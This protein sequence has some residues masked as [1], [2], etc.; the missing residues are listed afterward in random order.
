MCLHLFFILT[1]KQYRNIEISKKHYK[2]VPI[3]HTRFSLSFNIIYFWFPY[4][5]IYTQ[6]NRC[7]NQIGRWSG[8]DFFFVLLRRW[9][10]IGDVTITFDFLSFQPRT[11]NFLFGGK[12]I[13]KCE[14][15]KK[16]KEEYGDTNFIYREC[17]C[18]ESCLF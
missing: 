5:L 3:L 18:G 9:V 16:K 8:S 10:S 1:N 6:Q 15:C 17:C 7:N 13:Y 12:K 2:Y 11:I 14:G 4:I